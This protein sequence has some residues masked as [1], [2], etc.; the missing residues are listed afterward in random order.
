MNVTF[1]HAEQLNQHTKLLWFRPERQL[2]QI[3]GQF[4]ELSLPHADADDR[5]TKRWFTVS[6]SPTEPLLAITSRFAPKASSFKRHLATIKTGDTL[7]ISEALGDFVLPMQSDI[8]LIFVALGIGITPLRSIAAWL[9]DTHQYR[10]IDLLYAVRHSDDLLFLD[11]FQQQNMRIQT[12]INRDH[13]ITADY[14]VRDIK[15]DQDCLLYL[16][17]PELTIESLK[18][19]LK[20]LGVANRQIITDAFPG[21]I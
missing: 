19:D 1:D 8:R 4:V 6:S 21:Y 9:N 7:T 15:P 20:S 12:Y 17:G 18:I 11:I 5:G 3:A 14:I 2:D 10:D 13:E 16:S